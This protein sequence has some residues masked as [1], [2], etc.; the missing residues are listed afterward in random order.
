MNHI[1]PDIK[2]YMTIYFVA[3]NN[4]NYGIKKQY[5]AHYNKLFKDITKEK[6]D[7]SMLQI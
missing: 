2:V 4:Y 7:A 3:S 6:K 1:Y 5:H